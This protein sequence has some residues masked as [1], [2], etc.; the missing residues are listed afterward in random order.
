MIANARMYALNDTVATAW[1]RL[2]E[3][4]GLRIDKVTT[5]WGPPVFKNANL[6]RAI[7]RMVGKMLSAIPYMQY[8]FVFVLTRAAAS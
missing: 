4:A 2:F 1:R 6:K 8:Q 7:A 5:D 3:S